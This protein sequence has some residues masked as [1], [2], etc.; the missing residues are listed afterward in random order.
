MKLFCIFVV[1]ITMK[2]KLLL[3]L[4]AVFASVT[5]AQSSCHI[6]GRYQNK[7]GNVVLP[8]GYKQMAEV[9]F[10]RTLCEGSSYVL[11]VRIDKNNVADINRYGQDIQFK[12][13][14]FPS[15]KEGVDLNEYNKNISNINSNV[16]SLNEEGGVLVAFK[17]D[18][19]TPFQSFDIGFKPVNGWVG[20]ETNAF[21]YTFYANNINFNLA[22]FDYTNYSKELMAQLEPAAQLSEFVN[23]EPQVQEYIAP[24]IVPNNIK[25][26]D[27]KKGSIITVNQ[28]SC[29]LRVF[30]HLQEDGDVISVNFNNEWLIE[31][32]PL[33]KQAIVKTLQLKE[34][35]NF[36]ALHALNLGTISPNTAAFNLVFDGFVKKQVLFSDLEQTDILYIYYIPTEEKP[37]TMINEAE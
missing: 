18:A 2:T 36:I 27:I 24:V 16:F 5:Y 34:G 9:Q 15:S 33:K 4:F 11:H 23:A 20:M 28:P 8:F 29:E 17:I 21:E 6:Y 7:P 3:L 12:I 13:K 1:E 37:V 19:E 14:L 26:R 30:D 32:A 10:D 31:D 25:G 22:D 35:K